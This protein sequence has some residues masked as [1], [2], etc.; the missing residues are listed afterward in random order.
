MSMY[1]APDDD[2]PER[3]PSRTTQSFGGEIAALLFERELPWHA[4]AAGALIRRIWASAP[5]R[6]VPAFRS[7]TSGRWHAERHGAFGP[8]V[9]RIH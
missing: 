8:R 6:I 1:W 2:E 4:R 9:R 5:A 7:V 3:P